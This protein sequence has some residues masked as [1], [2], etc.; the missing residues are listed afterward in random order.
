MNVK[1]S[2]QTFSDTLEKFVNQQDQQ[3]QTNTITSLFNSISNNI[4][5]YTTSEIDGLRIC[6]NSKKNKILQVNNLEAVQ[7][8]DEL[9]K[10]LIVSIPTLSTKD[11]NLFLQFKELLN[12]SCPPNADPIMFE[13]ARSVA[14]KDLQKKFLL[15]VESFEQTL[16][17]EDYSNRD[18]CD[19]VYYHSH[20]YHKSREAPG[21]HLSKQFINWTL[22]SAF[23]NPSSV[24]NIIKAYVTVSFLIFLIEKTLTGQMDR[25]LLSK[26]SELDVRLDEEVFKGRFDKFETEKR[27][28]HRR[29][30]KR[31]PKTKSLSKTNKQKTTSPL[32]HTDIKPIINLERAP[33]PIQLT[34]SEPRQTPLDPRIATLK[35]IFEDLRIWDTFIRDTQSPDFQDI[36]W[37]HIAD[38]L[39][40]IIREKGS[41]YVIEACINDPGWDEA[42]LRSI[43]TG[44]W[45]EISFVYVLCEA[46]FGNRYAMIVVPDNDQNSYFEA[47]GTLAPIPHEEPLCRLIYTTA[48][49][50]LRHSFRG[51]HFIIE[52][53]G[54]RVEIPGD[55]H[56]LY[57]SI[58]EALKQILAE[59]G[60]LESDAGVDVQERTSEAP[61]KI[62]PIYSTS[63]EMSSST[64]SVQRLKTSAQEQAINNAI[65]I[66]D[67]YGKEH[68]LL[69]HDPDFEF[70]KREYPTLFHHPDIKE[71][72][73]TSYIQ[74]FKTITDQDRAEYSKNWLKVQGRL[75]V[76]SGRRFKSFETMRNEIEVEHPNWDLYHFESNFTIYENA[77]RDATP[78]QIEQYIIALGKQSGITRANTGAQEPNTEDNMRIT[79]KE[80]HPL[81]KE[82]QIQLYME[83]HVSS[84]VIK[85]KDNKSQALLRAKFNFEHRKASTKK[86]SNSSSSLEKRT[87]EV[88]K[89][90]WDKN[91]VHHY[92]REL[93]RIEEIRDI[94]NCLHRYGQRHSNRKDTLYLVFENS[95]DA[96]IFVRDVRKLINSVKIKHSDSIKMLPSDRFVEIGEFSTFVKLLKLNLQLEVEFSQLSQNDSARVD[97][98]FRDKMPVEFQ[99]IEFGPRL[100]GPQTVEIRE[101]IK[102]EPIEES[103]TIIFEEDDIDTNVPL[104]TSETFVNPASLTLDEAIARLNQQYA[105]DKELIVEVINSKTNLYVN[106]RR[107]FE[108][109]SNHLTILSNQEK[110][111]EVAHWNKLFISH[112][113]SETN[114]ET[115]MRLF[116]LVL[117][118]GFPDE[119]SYNYT[120][121]ILSRYPDMFEVMCRVI[122]HFSTSNIQPSNTILS[123]LNNLIKRFDSSTAKEYFQL[124]KETELLIN[125]GCHHLISSI[126]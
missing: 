11:Q 5:Q 109:I 115:L 12:R 15:L 51:N 90:D 47:G 64:E 29:K 30:T 80:N 59:A 36:W 107:L 74:S 53:N 87:Y 32:N 56:C 71:R 2:T 114:P 66:G 14:L 84:F 65:I 100:E 77:Y 22:G 34:V 19:T 3:Q 121:D 101:E 75:D 126:A 49:D 1:I 97:E 6:L 50:E 76:R 111:E 18:F 69:G 124:L 8:V 52:I 24:T 117:M 48:S 21:A 118:S 110:Y 85:K 20:F 120:I 7:K 78:E 86:H 119:R 25:T 9:K 55:G 102:I 73:L 99:E 54:R 60:L 116:D 31:I 82:P 38:I 96:E 16:T 35:S 67:K 40:K 41:S 81:W 70:L 46:L 72:L 23:Y 44:G 125:V 42:S 106:S 17:E 103:S 93:S 33:D 92:K 43:A 105:N 28:L 91:L 13:I 27:P 63:T 26:P 58:A 112:L 68:A 61:I 4:E 83:N 89:R 37:E 88:V 79:C 10:V 45:G 62:E 104:N 95:K 57:R 123:G 39:S 98:I 94:P 108:K 113:L 122:H